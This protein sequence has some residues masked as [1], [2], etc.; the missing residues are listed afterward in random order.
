MDRNFGGEGPPK[1]IQRHAARKAAR[2]FIRERQDAKANK[3]ET[4]IDSTGLYNKRFVEEGKLDDAIEEAKKFRLPVGFLAL[5]LDNFKTINDT[6]GHAAGDD[7]LKQLTEIIRGEIRKADIPLR[8][9][10][11][12]FGVLLRGTSIFDTES[13]FEVAERLRKKVKAEFEK[14]YPA[15][16]ISASIGCAFFEKGMDAKELIRKADVAQYHS[17]GPKKNPLK[18]RT[19]IFTPDMSMEAINDNGN[20]NHQ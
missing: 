16:S 7:A 5:D 15:F 2:T 17:K 1:P 18:D 12:E 14:L 4:Y 11:D 6:L 8:L 3:E 9:G 20:G 19:T 13:M 10:G